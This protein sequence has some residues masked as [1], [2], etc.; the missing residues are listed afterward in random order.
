MSAVTDSSPNPR[1]LQ[2]TQETATPETSTAS[3]AELLGMIA[4]V[5]KEPKLKPSAS[6]D[7]QSS[8]P[9]LVNLPS[10]VAPP[11][12]SMSR[13]AFAFLN[14]AGCF[15]LPSTLVQKMLITAYFEF[16]QPPLPLTD[17][18]QYEDIL[19][20][21]HVQHNRISL[22]LYT[23]LLFAGAIYVDQTQL[24]QAGHPVRWV[25]MQDLFE[26]AKV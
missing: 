3:Y 2:D 18:W 12:P 7:A 21:S 13:P 19:E 17:F 10:F 9:T 4:N 6:I 24:S 26:K 25:L 5:V 20:L 15:D 1:T 23:A 14:A 16:V 22:L 11:A 8:L